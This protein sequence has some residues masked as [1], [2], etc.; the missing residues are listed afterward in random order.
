M[1]T[2]L[3]IFNYLDLSTAHLTKETCDNPPNVI[4]GDSVTIAK[5][6][7]GFFMSMPC[8]VDDSCPDDLRRVIEYAEKHRCA[9][10]CFDSAS[11]FI[12]ALPRYDW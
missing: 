5:H 2:N 8:Q 6:Q 3:H 1:T 10:I 9:M 12:D 7:Y 4:G 11:S